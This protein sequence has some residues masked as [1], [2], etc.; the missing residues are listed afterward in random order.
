MVSVDHILA[1]ITEDVR[2]YSG[3][4]PQAAIEEFITGLTFD[5]HIAITTDIEE[6]ALDFIERYGLGHA[7]HFR[8]ADYEHGKLLAGQMF[9]ILLGH[10]PDMKAH[11]GDRFTKDDRLYLYIHVTNINPPLVRSKDQ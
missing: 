10:R 4:D 3:L 8:V 5:L 1:H 11:T 6:T 7:F 2:A 9:W